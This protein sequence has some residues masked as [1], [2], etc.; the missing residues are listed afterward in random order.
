MQ[1]HISQLRTAMTKASYQALA[2]ND[3]K[4][5]LAYR[6][7]PT[8]KTNKI[9]LNEDPLSAIIKLIY[10]LARD[11]KQVGY[12][13]NKLD[14]DGYESDTEGTAKYY[15]DLH[16][17][18][19]SKIR[20]RI[21]NHN[22]NDY[23]G[24]EKWY[25]SSRKQYVV[26]FVDPMGDEDAMDEF[27]AFAE[28]LDSRS[29][30]Y[31]NSQH[32]HLL[33]SL[34]VLVAKLD[35]IKQLKLSEAAKFSGH[36]NLNND[37]AFLVKVTNEKD[38]ETKDTQVVYHALVANI[39]VSSYDEIISTLVYKRYKSAEIAA[40]GIRTSEI[41]VFIPNA[42]P[43][44]YKGFEKN[45]AGK[46]SE[47]IN[48]SA[49]KGK[50]EISHID[51]KNLG[52]SG[53]LYKDSFANL[54]TEICEDAGIAHTAVLF[55]P[56]L[57]ARPFVR[58]PELDVN[59]AIKPKLTII[60]GIP[61]VLR[62]NAD[63]VNIEY[64]DLSKKPTKLNKRDDSNDRKFTLDF[65]VQ[66]AITAYLEYLKANAFAAYDVSVVDIEDIEYADLKDDV[67]YVFLQ[68]PEPAHGYWS[69]TSSAKL[70]QFTGEYG[71]DWQ[72][73]LHLGFSH[74]TIK[75]YRERDFIKT[76]RSRQSALTSDPNAV[77]FADTYT[78]WKIYQL[79]AALAGTPKKSLQ[80]LHIPNFATVA[81]QVI[82]YKKFRQ[83][84][85][86]LDHLSHKARLN[87]EKTRLMIYD[88]INIDLTMKNALTKKGLL[89]LHNELGELADYAAYVGN[90]RCYYAIRPKA[91]YSDGFY[92]SQI[93]FTVNA[94]GISIESVKLLDNESSIRDTG[95]FTISERVV[96]QF[97]ND[98]FYL[99]NE[100]GEVLTFY[101][102]KREEQPLA[103]IPFGRYKGLNLSDLYF[104]K[105]DRQVGNEPK[106]VSI[107]K[108][109]KPTKIPTPK[110]SES[111]TDEELAAYKDNALSELSAIERD[112]HHES[113]FIALSTMASHG[114]NK[115]HA[116]RLSHPDDNGKHKAAGGKEW[117]FF[118]ELPTGELLVYLT[119]KQDIQETKATA[120]RIYKMLVK[121]KEGNIL[122]AATSKLAML[123]IETA[124]YHV[125]RV[126]SFSAKSM[127]QS[128]AKIALKD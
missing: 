122:N 100:A 70:E 5:P 64:R 17:N 25:D 48:I 126:N 45:L 30:A 13:I 108:S 50:Q 73:H 54:L 52:E 104:Y 21:N 3:P 107:S 117:L 6:A 128:L 47:L 93:D 16:N 20:G 58:L 62:D 115:Y 78:M 26:L 95:D 103:C 32:Q 12:I 85:L 75:I 110:D 29:D 38:E 83:D 43:S 35:L 19:I 94:N 34:L 116:H 76:Y 27:I 42:L 7:F 101:T 114:T 39:W 121:D 1:E 4:L 74:P 113:E 51:L 49:A 15:T 77:F 106:P 44:R 125:A 56:D 10:L 41:D 61:H 53:L 119:D 9:K 36:V 98:G 127:L 59:A 102:S 60:I 88:K 65:I 69:V 57:R 84:D 24:Y 91:T 111:M 66:D 23:I 96:S 80:G 89:A 79:E 71:E 86:T 97:Y 28:E 123:Y 124:S 18:A 72:K 109:I 11:S 90:Y 81:A 22:P 37:I 33:N 92:A 87:F 63:V 82:G 112:K 120:N 40:D 55:D 46:G 67:D 118:K 99:V 14:R 8:A 2:D 105:L 31:T 68:E